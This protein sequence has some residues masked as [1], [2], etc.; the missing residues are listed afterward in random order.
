[1][2]MT[3]PVADLLT[4]I[5]NANRASLE[6]AVIP[7]SN[8]KENIVRVLKEEGFI[9]SYEVVG[10][11]IRKNM[12]VRLKYTA[13]KEH[14]IDQLVRVSKPGCRRYVGYEDIRPIRQGMGV[15]ILSTPK[16]VITD[17]AARKLKIG[18]E[19]ICTVW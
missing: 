15:A 17:T 11:G 14:V 18:G 19:W 6:I 1:M 2:N 9:K 8:L 13:K 10:E 16:G 7:H 4:R 5:R 3:D 12:V